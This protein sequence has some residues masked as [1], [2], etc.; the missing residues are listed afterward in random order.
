MGVN[1]IGTPIYREKK[2]NEKYFVNALLLFMCVYG[3]VTYF[4]TAM[5][6]DYYGFLLLPIIAVISF[7]CAFIHKSKRNMIVGYTIILIGYAGYVLGCGTIINSGFS[8]CLNVL[9]KAVDIRYVLGVD[10][11]YAEVFENSTMSVTMFAI[12][13]CFAM[14][15][16]VNMLISESMNGFAIAFLEMWFFLVPFYFGYEGSLI[17]CIM[18]LVVP[19]SVVIIKNTHKFGLHDNYVSYKNRPPKNVLEKAVRKVK[20]ENRKSFEN[21]YTKKG[22]FKSRVMPK[23]VA[24]QMLTIACI[25]AIV[26]IV[27]MT[28]VSNSVYSG[29]ANPVEQS[30]KD[31]VQGYAMYGFDSLFGRHNLANSG[32]N[33]KI[34]DNGYIRFDNMTDLK[35]T[36]RPQ[37]EERVLLKGYTG[38]NYTGDAW[39]NT[40]T[41]SN[42]ENEDEDIYSFAYFLKS[43]YHY[44]DEEIKKLLDEIANS[45]ALSIKNYN[46]NS[47][48]AYKE[49]M[50]IKNVSRNYSNVYLPYYTYFNEESTQDIIYSEL[51]DS[52]ADG[53][54]DQVSRRGEHQTVSYYGVKD[55]NRYISS[56]EDSEVQKLYKEYVGKTFLGNSSL[57]A[58][59]AN[60]FMKEHELTTIYDTKPRDLYYSVYG[61]DFIEE[62]K[63]V[64]K[65]YDIFDDE[66][67]YTLIPGKTPKDRDFAE[68]FLMTNK[69]GYCVHFATSAVVL[70]RQMGV[71]ARYC[72]GYALDPETWANGNT[73]SVELGQDENA[74]DAK[75]VEA[76]ITDKY[77]HAWI[78][79]Y[80]DGIGWYPVDITP[81]SYEDEEE[82][83]PE[84]SPLMVTLSRIAGGAAKA[85]NGVAKIFGVAVDNKVA[86]A[87]FIGSV[88]II[89]MLIWVMSIVLLH[90]YRL[91]RMNNKDRN[92]AVEAIANYARKLVRFGGVDKRDIYTFM[93]CAKESARGGNVDIV[94]AISILEPMQKIVYGRYDVNEDEYKE[95]YQAIKTL[96]RNVYENCRWHRKIKFVLI[97]RMTVIK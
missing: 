75:W 22:Y 8:H 40:T 60:E 1:I 20:K 13:V 96:S 67:R 44:N 64:Q 71:P 59:T 66:Y 17:S 46:E 95:A 52:D 36:F 80:A 51:R 61:Y 48:N 63:L 85:G 42:N 31:V 2:S 18:S 57:M 87:L 94:D 58:Y 81:P 77:G 6:I 65:L 76:D 33:G 93:E 89:F 79:I 21:K 27:V 50:I 23:V 19:V 47:D 97:K 30:I 69:K 68:Y 29:V 35:V 4:F 28:T 53:N 72:E 38:V 70:L 41:W 10:K 88:I 84:Q 7:G 55:V 90:Y 43:E 11:E 56:V 49:S 34:T 74:Q 91:S 78:E 32:M 16:M 73:S 83:Q 3:S 37:N 86:I 5:N 62:M 54:V 82:E 25:C 15:L 24:R 14:A 26:S 39:E 45:T 9:Y 92:I 12:A